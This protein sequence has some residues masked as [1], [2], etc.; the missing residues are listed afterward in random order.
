MDLASLSQT[1]SSFSQGQKKVIYTAINGDEI[2]ATR[3]SL[4]GPHDFVIQIENKNNLSKIKIPH[5]SL[6]SDLN[7]KL[8]CNKKDA[9]IL[10][11]IIEEVN[12]GLDPTK[13]LPTMSR[14]SFSNQ[15]YSSQAQR[16][17]QD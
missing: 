11:C 6:F 8:T 13:Y 14:L 16:T 2:T 4:F 12:K 9:E 3:T 10:F 1:L 5:I 17:F 15:L 7:T